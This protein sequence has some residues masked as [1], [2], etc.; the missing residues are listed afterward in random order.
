MR[1]KEDDLYSQRLYKLRRDKGMSQEELGKLLGIQ[2]TAVYK[3]EKGLTSIPQNKISKLCDIFKVPADYLLGRS[4]DSPED[5]KKYIKIKFY[6]KWT[7]QG[8][9]QAD[10]HELYYEALSSD[11]DKNEKE[12]F[13][14]KAI[15]ESMAPMYQDN[16]ILIIEKKS[17][18]QSGE[19]ALVIIG[20][21]DAIL[22]RISLEPDGMLLKCLNP[23][24]QNKFYTYDDINKI[25][26]SIIGVAKELRRKINV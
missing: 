24:F 14:I 17:Q 7:A 21:S 19:D 8:P 1:Y 26:V 5:F 6:D 15:G 22:R 23:D 9:I 4:N 3:Y 11:A 10:E 13:A 2:K 20:N 18:C 25:P 16:D 12:L